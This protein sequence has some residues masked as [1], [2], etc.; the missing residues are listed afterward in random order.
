MTI[1]ADWRHSPTRRADLRHSKEASGWREY[2]Y[3]WRVSGPI[4][5]AGDIGQ[6]HLH[7]IG[8]R[9]LRLLCGRI[10]EPASRRAHVPEIA[11]DEVALCRIVMQ[12]GRERR[13]GV[14]LRLAIAESRA[15]RPRVSA[16]GPV[17]LRHRTGKAG[18]G[19]VAESASL[20]SGYRQILVI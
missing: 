9:T 2:R 13:V 8:G 18:L 7:G 5:C 4:D 10:A 12:H 14:R 15:H 17:Q 6:P 3:C 16:R 20:V 1:P 19:H 11:A